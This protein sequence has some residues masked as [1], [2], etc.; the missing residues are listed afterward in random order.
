MLRYARHHQELD[1]RRHPVLVW[2]G[3]H[4]RHCHRG[5]EAQ[6][7]KFWPQEVQEWYRTDLEQGLKEL[8]FLK[9]AV[10][11]EILEPD[12]LNYQRGS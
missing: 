6:A 12:R 10:T 2:R 8:R 7:L 5:P 11:K 3:R 4:R 1:G 9:A